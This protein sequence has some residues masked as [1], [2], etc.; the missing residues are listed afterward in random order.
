[1]AIWHNMLMECLF[2]KRLR[3]LREEKQLGQGALGVLVNVSQA[4]VAKWESG[5]REPT[6]E[7]LMRLCDIFDVTADYLLGRASD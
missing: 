6:F 7:M 5:D 3:E 1:M 2:A 4:A